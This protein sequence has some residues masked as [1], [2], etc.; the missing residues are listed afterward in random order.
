MGAPFVDYL[1]ADRHVIPPDD[2]RHFSESI[3]YL[4]TCY[5]VNGRQ[6]ISPRTPTRAECGL[7]EHGFVFCCFN[8]IQKLTPPVF[9]RWMRILVE[10]EGGV[11]WLL[12]PDGIAAGNLREHAVARGVAPDRLVFAP[13]LPHADHLARYRLADLFLD[14]LP[15]N[16]HTTA[17]DALRMGCPVLTATGTTFAGRVATSLLHAVGAV[18]LVTRDLAH[19]ERRAIELARSPAVFGPIRAKVRA[20][21]KSALFDTDRTRRALEGAYR[22]MWDRY[23][24]GEQAESFSVEEGLPADPPAA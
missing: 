11:L 4:P 6:E 8:N 5:Q 15:Y 20:A 17:S 10:T 18:E 21:P 23:L 19:Y 14:T 13:P 1:I 22:G 12:A 2:R 16:A 9:D 3:V 7:P 24:A